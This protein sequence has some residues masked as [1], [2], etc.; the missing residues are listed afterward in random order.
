MYHGGDVAFV[1]EPAV[2]PVGDH[3]DVAGDVFV[4]DAVEHVA[5]CGSGMW[6]AT[7]GCHTEPKSLLV[8]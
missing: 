8:R 6:L 4:G 7:L 1:A 5:N 3:V 2:S